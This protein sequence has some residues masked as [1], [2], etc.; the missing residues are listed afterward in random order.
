[1]RI[2]VNVI[3]EPGKVCMANWEMRKHFV[4]FAILSE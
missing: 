3:T 2:P 1:M 4:D